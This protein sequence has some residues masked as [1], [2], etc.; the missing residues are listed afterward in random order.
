M[1]EWSTRHIYKQDC[2]CCFVHKS[3]ISSICF[4]PKDDRFFVSACLSGQLR[5]WSIDEKKIVRWNEINR[6]QSPN[7]F[8]TAI[9]FCQEGK[10]IAVGTYD[11]KCVLYQTDVNN[12][13]FKQSRLQTKT[14]FLIFKQ[15]LKYYSLINAKSRHRNSKNNKITGIEVLHNDE[16]KVWKIY[17]FLFFSIVSSILRF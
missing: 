16:N 7:C 8:V 17:F 12:F 3:I 1:Y 9:C 10:T 5:L 2:L 15:H 13:V 6:N 4:H 11:G 14:F